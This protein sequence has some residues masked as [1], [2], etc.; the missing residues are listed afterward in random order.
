MSNVRQQVRAAI[1]ACMSNAIAEGRD[2]WGAARAE[3]PGTP[4]GVLGEA[5]GDAMN[6]EEEAWWQT[7]ERTIDVEVIRSAIAGAGGS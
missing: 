5:F 6:A 4:M 1:V 3:F 7:V 2:P